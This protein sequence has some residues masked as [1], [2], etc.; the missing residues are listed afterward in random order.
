VAAERGEATLPDGAPAR[1]PG[2]FPPNLWALA[3]ASYLRDVASEMLT[4]LV[5]LFLANV[6]GTR[7][8]LVGL[9]EGLAETTASLT[10]IAAGHLSD[11][12]GRR[13]PLTVGGYAV[14][15]VGV[16]VL[17]VAASWLQVLAARLLDRLGKGLRTAPR[18][19]LLA[20]SLAAARRGAGF[21]LH[22]AAD[23]AGAV[24]GLL[25][26]MALVWRTQQGAL[27]LS[28]ETFRTVA[29]WALVPALAAPLVVA[30]GVRERTRARVATTRTQAATGSLEPRFRRFLAVTVL[31]T[32]GNASDAFLVLR[33]QAAGAGVLEVLGMLTLFN[34]VCSLLATPLG[35]LS[36][37]W[38]RRRLIAGGWLLYAAVYLG[39]G[40]ASD[41]SAYW[42]LWAVYGTY[43]ALTEGT[44]KAL[45]ADL[46]PERARGTAYGFYH[47]AVGLAL[48]P[49]SLL[50]GVLWQGLGSWAGLGPAAP[51]LFGATLSVA[52]AALLLRWV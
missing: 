49:A 19:A 31:F 11:R 36:D 17:M 14:S 40:L 24:T 34:L 15:A 18:D 23:T 27:S 13:K 12:S 45:V 37:R 52:A 47:G 6:L 5:P 48:L 3:L 7:L 29:A 4:H 30:W 21:G 50:A 26:A 25:V 20:D 51:F 39:F 8:S 46:V 16:P 2:G 43:Y 28:A 41:R 44:A 38:P 33:T 35:A 32:L 22:R 9:I 1:G 42:A 10:K